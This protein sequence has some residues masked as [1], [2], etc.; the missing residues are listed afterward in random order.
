MP[1]RVTD[2]VTATTPLLGDVPRSDDS[3]VAAT[4]N[5]VSTVSQTVI[6]NQTTPAARPLKPPLPPGQPPKAVVMAR[7]ARMAARSELKSE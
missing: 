7:L 1:F 6:K 2:T 3:V 4:A 5:K